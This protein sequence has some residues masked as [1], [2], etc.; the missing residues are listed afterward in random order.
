MQAQQGL[1][2]IKHRLQDVTE[3]RHHLFNLMADNLSNHTIRQVQKAIGVWPL[4]HLTPVPQ[5][6]DI[7][8][9][10]DMGTMTL[11][12]ELGEHP[13]FFLF[14]LIGTELRMGVKVPAD[15]VRQHGLDAKISHAVDGKP[16][17]R[18]EDIGS[19]LLF[20]WIY[21]FPELVSPERQAWA[22][23][24]ML[25][26]MMHLYMS[27]NNAILGA[28][29]LVNA[30]A[31]EGGINI[32]VSTRAVDAQTALY[33]P[34]FHAVLSAIGQAGIWVVQSYPQAPHRHLLMLA[35]KDRDLGEVLA[36][37][38][39]IVENTEGIRAEVRQVDEEICH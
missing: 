28:G 18:V 4:A 11:R 17:P 5:R 15:L 21:Q 35:A 10:A 22:I 30:A 29:V 20:D 32:L 26:R 39:H 33:E 24:E 14:F 12:V 31:E 27:I 36:L 34:A 23:D 13:L 7:A 19:F 9:V 38:Q 25:Q 3:F 2:L 37:I 1:E 6:E 8:I 16:C